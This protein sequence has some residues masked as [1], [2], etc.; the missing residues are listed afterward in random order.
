MKKIVAQTTREQLAAIVVSKLEEKGISAFLVG[1][2]VVSIY[3][4]NEY[5]SK[6][7]AVSLVSETWNQLN[8]RVKSKSMG[9][10]LNCIHLP[11]V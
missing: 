11:N 8:R 3:T 2:S 4:D 1:G 10:A 6:D 7:L 5:A 9:L